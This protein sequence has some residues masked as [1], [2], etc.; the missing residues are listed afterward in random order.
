MED[1]D[2]WVRFGFDRDWGMFKWVCFG[3]VWVRFWGRT[4]VFGSARRE[5]WVRLVK[6]IAHL[7]H[8]LCDRGYL[9]SI[10]AI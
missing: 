3:F 2:R 9:L 4:L 6:K 7:R 8:F 10:V 1:R 5:K